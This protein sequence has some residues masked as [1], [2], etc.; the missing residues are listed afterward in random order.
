MKKRITRKEW[1]YLGKYNYA[2]PWLRPFCSYSLMEIEGGFRRDCEVSWP[3]Y[4]IIFLPVHLL[5]AL[6]C[7]WDGGL[8][9]FEI[10][11]RHLGHNYFFEDWSRDEPIY[12]KAKE[13]WE[14]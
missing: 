3:V 12:P 14:K 13:I 6:Y 9:E 4:L 1:E 10:Y 8:K 2:A 11:S 5:Q 7:I